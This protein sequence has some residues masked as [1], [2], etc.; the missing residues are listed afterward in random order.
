M[1]ILIVEDKECNIQAARIQLAEHDVTIVTGFDQAY[2][3]L[4]FGCFGYKPL[5]NPF[6][7]VLTDNFLP[8]GGDMLMGPEGSQKAREQGA[9]PYG[10]VIALYAIQT[11]VKYV[12]IH[13]AGNHHDDPFS[14]A[15]EGLKGTFNQSVLSTF[16]KYETYWDGGSKFSHPAKHQYVL[17]AGWQV[18]KNWVR[19][20]ERMLD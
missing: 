5:V 9:M 16:L 13:S 6:E 3:A 4:G 1:K 11:G 18:V 20:L 14:F 7:V 12:G 17:P 10:A 19:A 8:K 15:L 2:Q